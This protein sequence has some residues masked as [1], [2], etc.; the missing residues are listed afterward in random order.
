[1]GEA[2]ALGLHRRMEHRRGGRAQL[3]ALK[4]RVTLKVPQGLLFRQGYIYISNPVV[5][6]SLQQ[7]LPF[8]CCLS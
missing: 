8:G 6:A 4:Q 1:M 5:S 7:P 2:L 3:F